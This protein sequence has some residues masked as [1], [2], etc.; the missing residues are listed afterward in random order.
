MYITYLDRNLSIFVSIYSV[1]L[2]FLPIYDSVDNY[3]FAN[4]LYTFLSIYIPIYLYIFLYYLSIYLSIYLPTYPSIY[5]STYPSIYISMYN[6]LNKAMYVMV[7]L[8]YI[9]VGNGDISWNLAWMVLI[10]LINIRPSDVSTVH[11]FVW[12]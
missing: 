3:L 10:D 2:Y 1:C 8:S 11:Y 4:Y 5:L 9:M 6:A 7:S 12:S